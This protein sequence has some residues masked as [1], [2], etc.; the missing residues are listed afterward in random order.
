M[1]VDIPILQMLCSGSP[2]KFLPSLELLNVPK[3]LTNFDKFP[4]EQVKKT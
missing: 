2:S 1:S 3:S 4:K